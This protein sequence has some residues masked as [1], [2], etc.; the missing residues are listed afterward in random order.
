MIIGNI[1]LSVLRKNTQLET[2]GN[3]SWLSAVI[4]GNEIVFV[5]LSKFFLYRSI[6]EKQDIRSLELIEQKLLGLGAKNGRTVFFNIDDLS[7]SITGSLDIELTFDFDERYKLFLD[8]LRNANFIVYDF[9]S[10]IELTQS[11]VDFALKYNQLLEY[12]LYTEIGQRINILYDIL[13]EKRI[14]K[15]VVTDLDNTYWGGVVGDDGINGIKGIGDDFNSFTLYQNLLKRLK[16]RGILLAICS[17]NHEE[18]VISAL[19]SEKSL[20]RPEDFVC[21]K[22]NWSRKSQN[23]LEISKELNLSTRNFIFIDDNPR[24]R[25]EVSEVIRDIH[26]PAMPENHWAWNNFL[27]ETSLFTALRISQE[28]FDRTD[29]YKRDNLR[30]KLEVNS[31]NSQ[32]YLEKLKMELNVELFNSKN[33]ERVISLAN[34]TNQWNTNTVRIENRMF[35]EIIENP[36]KLGL[37]IRV[38]DVFG[39]NGLVI[40]IWGEIDGEEF[41]IVNWTMSCR[42]IGRKL[43]YAT[44]YC[45]EKLLL[46]RGVV[47]IHGSV[48]KND[49]NSLVHEIYESLDFKKDKLEFN[50]VN[51][52]FSNLFVYE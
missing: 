20:L 32:V 7:T 41:C 31:G 8:N 48:L 10:R 9:S 47:R 30:R 49:R 43:E 40:L 18:N 5:L 27:L 16:E 2:L 6:C 35:S 52:E 22:A 25:L 39:D 38:S 3:N 36:N 21:I 45:L 46:P 34:R 19:N 26:V 12:S 29:Y 51:K 42:V 33:Q 4:E 17:K 50:N 11:R 28:D 24:E 44:L 1:D 13:I 14:I 15:V 23:I 37:A